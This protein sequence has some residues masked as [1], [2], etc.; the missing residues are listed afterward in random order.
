[1][2]GDSLKGSIERSV[3]DS[4]DDSLRDSVFSMGFNR[5]FSSMR[6]DKQ[7]EE[8]FKSAWRD[9]FKTGFF[10]ALDFLNW[11]FSQDIEVLLYVH[12]RFN[13]LPTESARS[14]A[15]EYTEYVIVH[16]ELVSLSV[17]IN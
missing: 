16:K 5:G 9:W 2:T 8:I 6:T 10:D 4:V 13:D 12:S 3:W 15:R 14:L 11:L 1:M 17:C 7:L